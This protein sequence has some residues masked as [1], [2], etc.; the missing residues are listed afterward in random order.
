MLPVQLE[1]LMF[2]PAHSERITHISSYVRG[3]II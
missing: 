2:V 1:Y 3:F